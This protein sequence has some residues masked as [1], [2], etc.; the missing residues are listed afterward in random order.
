MNECY[1]VNKLNQCYCF[2]RT[3]EYSSLNNLNRYSS[4]N[5]TVKNQNEFVNTNSITIFNDSELLRDPSGLVLGKD[6][7]G[8]GIN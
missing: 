4:F 1:C 7:S 3:S 5:K 8:N 2:N 6:P